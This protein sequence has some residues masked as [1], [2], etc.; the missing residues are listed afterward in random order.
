MGSTVVV[1]L[2]TGAVRWD[3][4]LADGIAVRMGKRSADSTTGPR[5]STE[6]AP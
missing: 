2:G 6:R 4:R 5:R 1:L 3:P